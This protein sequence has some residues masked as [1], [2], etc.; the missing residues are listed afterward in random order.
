ME[1]L[2]SSSRFSGRG[3]K[4]MQNDAG[5]SVCCF[6]QMPK[7]WK[8]RV[9]FVGSILELDL[10][11]LMGAFSR[12][13]LFVPFGSLRCDG[14]GWANFTGRIHQVCA[15]CFVGQRPGMNWAPPKS[16]CLL[17]FPNNTV[18]RSEEFPTPACCVSNQRIDPN[19]SSP[20]LVCCVPNETPNDPPGYVI[21][22][23]RFSDAF[24]TSKLLVKS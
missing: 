14:C 20:A 12:E 1:L 23:V 18:A 5:L 24:L 8:C 11:I 16:I 15:C 3:T 4:Q 2:A 21:C 22:V 9:V 17:C 7:K 13:N 6:K 10:E 19:R